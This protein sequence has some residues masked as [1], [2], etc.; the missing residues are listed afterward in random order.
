MLL[1]SL[2]GAQWQTFMVGQPEVGSLGQNR[3]GSNTQILVVDMM[4]ECGVRR[5]GGNVSG[6]RNGGGYGDG[7]RSGGFGGRSNGPRG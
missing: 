6:N 3:V 5:G 7:S 1:E 2:L 4:A